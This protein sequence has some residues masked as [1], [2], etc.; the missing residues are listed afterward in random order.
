MRDIIFS[1]AVVPIVKV[2]EKVLHSVAKPVEVIDKKILDLIEDMKATLLAQDDPKGVGLAA[3]QVG[4][5]LRI[6]VTKPDDESD[7][8]VFI[9]PTILRAYNTRAPK[10]KNKKPE[11]F[12][13][14]LSIPKLW[15]VVTRFDT[16]EVEYMDEHGEKQGLGF[17]GFLATIIQHEVDHLNGI[18]FTQRVL[19]QKEKLYKVTGRDK[20]GEDIFEEVSIPLFK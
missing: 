20:K 18:L 7:F 11:A 12:E 5:S 6:F 9:N 15:G 1:M 2:P 19:E 3:P 14:C 4:K 10:K 16:V 17:T 13:G 8:M